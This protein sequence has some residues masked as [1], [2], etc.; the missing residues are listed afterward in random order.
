MK[1]AFLFITA[2]LTCSLSLGAPYLMSIKPPK[3]QKTLK[4]VYIRSFS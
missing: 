4:V 1:N 3:E 2:K